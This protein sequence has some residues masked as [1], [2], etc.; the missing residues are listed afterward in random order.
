MGTENSSYV[1]PMGRMLFLLGCVVVMAAWSPPGFAQQIFVGPGPHD[2]NQTGEEQGVFIDNLGAGST[3]L[4]GPTFD[5]IFTNN[6]LVDGVS[7]IDPTLPAV[8]TN[9]ASLTDIVFQIDSTVYGTIG[10]TAIFRDITAIDGVTVNFLGTVNTTTMNV[11]TGRVNFNSGTI[12]NVGAVTFTGDGTVSL[13]P[14]TTMTG[15]LNAAGAETGTLVLGSSSQWTGAVGAAGGLKAIEVVGDGV[16]ATITGQVDAFTFNLGSNTLLIDGLLNVLNPG[17]VTP[18]INTTLISN[19][20]FGNITKLSGAT[21]F[22]GS[23][24]VNVFVPPGSVLVPGDLFT[25]VDSA[26]GTIN[27]PI[28]VTIQAPTN[29]LYTFE[30]VPATTLNGSVTIQVTGIPLTVV[31]DPIVDVILEELP[32]VPGLIPVVAAIGTLTDPVA[33]AVN[34][35]QL[36]PSTPSLAAPQVTFEKSRQFQNLWLSRLDICPKDSRRFYEKNPGACR[37]SDPRDGW[38]LRGFGYVGD[39]D[40]RRD[41]FGYDSYIAGGMM[42]YDVPLRPDTRAGVGVGYARSN[43]DGKTH[44]TEIDIDS[45]QATA[46]IG[47]ERGPWF[48]QGAASFSWNEYS[49]RRHIV[50]PL[51]LP[52]VDETAKAD[53]SGQDYTAYARAGYHFYLPAEEVRITPNASIQYSHVRLDDYTEKGAGDLNLR[54][55]S[56]SYNFAESGLGVKADRVFT[57]SRDG[58]AVIPEIHFN[59]FY[60]LSNP[61]PKQIT[62][63]VP[64]R[65]STTTRGQDLARSTFNVGASLQLLSCDSCNATS[66]SLDAGYDYFWRNDDFSAHQGTLRLTGRF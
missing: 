32:V 60:R 59:W 57:S 53:Y 44:D 39:Q 17:T 13:A 37:D 41:S 40:V 63:F 45:Y 3:L 10:A 50:L 11:G 58:K 21:N 35:R 31:D 36:V 19:A 4:I 49:D 29:P 61:T 51:A 22:A 9:N 6:R 14:N 65:R 7:A 8:D 27:E 16:S 34:L 24:A 47:Q 46:Y 55:D 23:V 15:A 28:T 43:I 38:W 48:I 42:G 30:A 33:V 25:I 52:S 64:G 62:K 56:Q 2:L 18:T 1:T 12:T 20:T 66:W 54:A 5:D 26:S